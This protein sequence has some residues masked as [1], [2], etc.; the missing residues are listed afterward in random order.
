MAVH[1]L[2]YL[3]CSKCGEVFKNEDGTTMYMETPEEVRDEAEAL[4]WLCYASEDKAE[5]QRDYCPVC[6][7]Q[8]AG[9]E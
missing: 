1:E 4:G 5:N 3:T 2:V 8:E 9:D 6:K 7:I